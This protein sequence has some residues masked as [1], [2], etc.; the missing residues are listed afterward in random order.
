MA[1]ERSNFGVHL[2]A[3][4]F[5]TSPLATRVSQAMVTKTEIAMLRIDELPIEGVG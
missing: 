4:G 2:P 1:N 3:T 5:S